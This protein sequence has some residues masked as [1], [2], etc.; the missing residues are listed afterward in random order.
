MTSSALNGHLTVAQRTTRSHNTPL[1]FGTQAHACTTCAMD[2]LV[3]FYNCRRVHETKPP[4]SVVNAIL[5]KRISSSW[6][7]THLCISSNSAVSWKKAESPP[8]LDEHT[9][10][11]FSELPTTTMYFLATAMDDSLYNS[12]P[13]N[14][15]H[16]YCNNS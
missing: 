9:P 16:K 7:D 11:P 5:D 13:A 8:Q 3:H 10:T 1:H 6:E 12:H 15:R 4:L 2:T 14:C